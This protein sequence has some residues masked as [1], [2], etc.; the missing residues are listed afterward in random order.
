[1]PKIKPKVRERRDG[2]FGYIIQLPE[3]V[4]K[5]TGLSTSTFNSEKDALVFAEEVE[6]RKTSV[7]KQSF[8]AVSA[9]TVDD[10]FRWY[11]TTQEFRTI[12]QNSKTSYLGQMKS[13]LKADISRTVV[14]SVICP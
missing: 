6:R 2:S 12:K 14:N 9:E 3:D 8:S 10:L 1:M 11:T 4:K 7:Y 5:T 13:H